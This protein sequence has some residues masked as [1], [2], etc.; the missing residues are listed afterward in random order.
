[1]VDK[2]KIPKRVGRGEAAQEG[3][4][5]SEEGDQGGDQPVRPRFRHRGDGGGR[6]RARFGKDRR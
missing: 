4:Q 5:E 1:M 6:P 2:V 3:P